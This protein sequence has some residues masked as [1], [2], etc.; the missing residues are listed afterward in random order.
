MPTNYTALAVIGV[1]DGQLFIADRLLLLDMFRWVWD[2]R[3]RFW[4]INRITLPFFHF[5]F[6]FLI[7]SYFKNNL[8]IF[9][10]KII[11][12]KDWTKKI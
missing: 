6:Y 12:V 11:G 4:V 9:V 3:H 1:A 10:I 8:K 2:I 5:S 7:F